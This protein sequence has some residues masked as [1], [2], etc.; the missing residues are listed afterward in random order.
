MQDLDSKNW[1]SRNW[2]NWLTLF[3]HNKCVAG[4]MSSL[5]NEGPKEEVSSPQSDAQIQL[6]NTELVDFIKNN[7]EWPTTLVSNDKL[8]LAE[9]LNPK[10]ESAA[11]VKGG[12]PVGKA[13]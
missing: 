8:N 10:V 1:D 11:P 13:A 3:I 9:V 5:L 7:G 4:T 12:K 2:S 6:D